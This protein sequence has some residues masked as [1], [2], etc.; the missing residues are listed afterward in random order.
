MSLYVLVSSIHSEQLPHYQH[1]YVTVGLLVG[2]WLGCFCLS[3]VCIMLGTFIGLLWVGRLDTVLAY[4]SA[5]L[6]NLSYCSRFILA[7]VEYRN[8]MCSTDQLLIGFTRAARPI[9]GLGWSNGESLILTA[10][11]S[12]FLLA[13]V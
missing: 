4:C 1:V 9:S 8:Q 5:P 7:V 10:E 13:S 3:A 6:F 11:N 12:L 2:V